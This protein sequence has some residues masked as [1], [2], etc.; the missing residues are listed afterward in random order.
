[1]FKKAFF[2]CFIFIINTYANLLQDAIDSSPA[3]STLKLSAGIYKGSITITK[4]INIIGKEDGVIIEGEGR[5]NIITIKSSHVKLKN[6]TITNSGSR[7]DTMDS[8]V[9][10]NN[11]K[12]VNI[13]NCTIKNSL[14]GVFLDNVHNSA[15]QNSTVSSNAESI[16]FRGDALRLWFSHNNTI[17][18]NKFIKSRDIVLMRS[19][20]NNISKNYM[21]E[22]R[23]A[24]FTQHSKN[25]TVIDNVL[26]DNAVGIFLEASRDINVSSNSIKGHHGAQTSLGIL[27]KAA[28][29]IHVEK[30]NIAEC[31]QALYIDNSPKVRDTKNWILDNKII[32]S[33]KGLNFKNYSVKNVIKR[34]ELF[35]NMD[36]VMSDSR[37][38]LTN[39]NEVESNYWDDYEGFDVNRDNIGDTPH[40]KYLYLDALLVKNPELGF[41]Y[42]STALSML[43]FLL[44][45]APFIQPVFLV[46]DKKP[47]FKKS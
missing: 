33:T 35:G 23:Y 44:K 2:I 18:N 37:S 19:N 36:N 47:I 7:L 11:A 20:D 42:G 4:P 3:G 32:Y 14:F 26:K 6:L 17:Q 30:N 28:S 8:A 5:G 27:L 34:N 24:I 43:N 12:H 25:I 40:K 16:G 31:N 41:F 13:D 29:N 39:Q 1:M 38:G 21:Q 9:F 22:C 15:I 45:I 10:I 46:E